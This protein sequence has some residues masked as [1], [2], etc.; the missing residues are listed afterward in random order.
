MLSL[1]VDKLDSMTNSCKRL[2][3]KNQ[4][5]KCS[6]NKIFFTTLQRTIHNLIVSFGVMYESKCTSCFRLVGFCKECSAHQYV[7][8]IDTDIIHYFEV[9]ISILNNKLNNW[10]LQA[11]IQLLSL[12]SKIITFHYILVVWYV[13]MK[14]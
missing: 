14:V 9:I 10:S 13:L 4:I 7:S 6:P 2:M 12:S 11:M 5:W 1:K 8:Q 3:H